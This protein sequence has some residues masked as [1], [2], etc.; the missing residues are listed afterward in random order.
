MDLGELARHLGDAA[1][2]VRLAGAEID[3]SAKFRG[4]LDF[5][6]GLAEKFQD[7]P[8]PLAEEDSLRSQADM[9]LAPAEQGPAHLPFQILQ[10]PRQRGLCDMDELGR[11]GDISLPRNDQEIFQC[12]TVHGTHLL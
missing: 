8:G 9:A 4:R 12:F 3:I 1:D 11:P 6:P 7:L 2:H 5:G 10:L